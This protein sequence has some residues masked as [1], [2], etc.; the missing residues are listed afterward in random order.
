MLLVGRQSA[1]C[2]PFRREQPGVAAFPSGECVLPTDDG[3]P[4]RGRRNGRLLREAAVQGGGRRTRP[5]DVAVLEIT[6]HSQ[7]P[8]ARQHAFAPVQGWTPIILSVERTQLQSK[9]YRLKT[10][11]RWTTT[12]YLGDLV[13][14]TESIPDGDL[15][16]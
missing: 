5:K 11:Q 1:A 15:A 8:A 16:E 3:R 12:A 9:G 13:H 6:L 2:L 7:Q 14:T 10:G 4:K